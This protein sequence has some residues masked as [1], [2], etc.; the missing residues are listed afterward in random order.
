MASSTSA[1]TKGNPAATGKG[2]TGG[3]KKTQVQPQGGQGAQ[4][5]VQPQAGP[6]LTDYLT[7]MLTGISESQV[8]GTNATIA[9]VGNAA[10]EIKGSVGNAAAEIKGNTK[11]EAD[12]VIKELSLEVSIPTLVVMIV[13]AV[14]VGIVAF[15]ATKANPDFT[16]IGVVYYTAFGA[17]ATFLTEWVLYSIFKSVRIKKRR[18]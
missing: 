10:A 11:T 12:R 17:V 2:A 16:T 5:Q 3:K 4:P 6:D 9:S 18:G 13:V 1:K 15:F 7:A 14:I 8:N